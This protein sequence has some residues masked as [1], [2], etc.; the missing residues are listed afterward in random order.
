MCVG[1]GDVVALYPSL[2]HKESMRMCG[3]MVRNAPWTFENIDIK[4]AG[5]FVA[6][7]FSE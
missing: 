3:D 6:T 5:V 7:S 4:A 1:S 2:R